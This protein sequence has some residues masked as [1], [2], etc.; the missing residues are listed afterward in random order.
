MTAPAI[1]CLCPKCRSA[2]LA[3][4]RAGAEVL[5]TTLHLA[6]VL[7]QLRGSVNT[8]LVDLRRAQGLMAQEGRA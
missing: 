1:G 6:S 8:E 7:A 3:R 5:E 2:R 4:A